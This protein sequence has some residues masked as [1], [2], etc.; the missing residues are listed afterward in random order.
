MMPLRMESLPSVGSTSSEETIFNGA[1]SGFCS[2][3]ASAKAS[4]SLKW[5]VISP[6]PVSIALWMFGAE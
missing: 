1:R 6:L 2:T 5:P 4:W 3:F